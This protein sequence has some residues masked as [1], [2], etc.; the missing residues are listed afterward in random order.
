L[1]YIVTALKSEAQA[2]VDKHKLRPTKLSGFNVFT[3][4][5]IMLIVSGIGVTSSAHAT[6]ALINHYDITDEDIYLNIGIC[7]ASEQYDIGQLLEIGTIIYNNKSM[8]LQSTSPAQLNCVEHEISDN[9]YDIVDMESF[10]FYDAVIHSPAI[11][12][13]HVLK[14]VSDHFEPQKVTKETT[15]SLIF[16][17]IDAINLILKREDHS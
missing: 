15:K 2:F 6:Q 16:N 11:K 5:S 8:P 4:D 9:T 7:G 14:V 12:N 17:Q 13:Y 1:L 10:G 3:S